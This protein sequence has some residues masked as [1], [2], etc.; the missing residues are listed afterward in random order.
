MDHTEQTPNNSQN[1]QNPMDPDF[2][3]IK[4]EGASEATTHLYRQFSR[5]SRL[6]M[7]YRLHNWRAHGPMG[8]PH[9]G[10]GRILALLKLQ[11]EVS[12]KDLSYLLEMRP[13]SLG[14]LLSKLETAGYITRSQST[15]DKRV[16]MIKLTEKGAEVADQRVKMDDLFAVLSEEEQAQFGQYLERLI[17]AMEE[18]VDKD[19]IAEARRFGPEGA[20]GRGPAGRRG[21]GGRR[22]GRG[23]GRGFGPEGPED[24]GPNPEHLDPSRGLR[25][26]RET[27]QY[28]W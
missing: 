19:A 14:E 12:Q 3:E 17:V 5:L 16:Q 22:G 13:Q 20:W 24:F 25:R 6:F 4:M 23:F 21:P 1:E 11:P 27:R 7:V 28:V 15:D 8:D 26:F 18:R 10:Q 2:A 9:R